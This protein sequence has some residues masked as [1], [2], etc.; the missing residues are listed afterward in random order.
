MEVWLRGTKPRPVFFE[1][2]LPAC[3]ERV[4]EFDRFDLAGGSLT[5]IFTGPESKITLAV[6]NG[7]LRFRQVFHDSFWLNDPG[8]LF[9]QDFE[10][11]RSPWFQAEMSDFDGTTGLNIHPEQR[12]PE[13]VVTLPPEVRSIGF[14]LAH[15]MEG[16]VRV[17]GEKVIAQVV[18]QDLRR[19][20]LHVSDTGADCHGN[21][22]GAAPR[23]VTAEIEESA[24]RQTMI[25]FGGT[26]IPTAFRE[27]SD[28]GKQRFWD[29][30]E[31]YNLRVQRENPI[32]GEL[33]EAMDNWDDPASAVPHYYGDSF[34]NGNISDFALNRGFQERGGQVWFEYWHFPK[35]M[36]RE[37]E[38]YIDE[39]GVERRNPVRVDRYAASI[40][41]YCRRAA[42]RT[43]RPP[44]IVGVQ[45]EQSHPKATYHKMV[46]AL[47][48]ALDEA[49][50][51][52][53]RIHMSDANMLS[54]DSS[55]GRLYADSITR[56]KTFREN[57]DTWAAIDYSTAHMYDY[58]EY[59]DD[60]DAFDAPMD[61]LHRLND[62]KPFLST[63]LCVNSPR[64]QMR[65]YRLA[66]LMGELMHKNLARLDA[67]AVLF[68]WTLL[69]VEQPTYAW[70]R[71]LLAID[72]SRGGL[73]VP[74]SHQL[75]VYGAWSRRV[76][77]GMRRVEVHHGEPDLMAVAFVGD[78]GEKTWVGLNRS[79]A[80]LRVRL[81]P[82][83][84]ADFRWME[85]VS[86]YAENAVA[87]N[88]PDDP[89]EIAPGS[90]I[91]LSNVPI[92][93]S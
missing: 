42:E 29:Y 71:A 53:V 39:K 17:N 84:P 52:E 63:E 41:D 87:E 54:P 5:W 1:E 91:T 36:T 64:Y 38:T 90:I 21:L 3:F 77:E 8:L 74:G 61:E 50:F 28:E 83:R 85:T 72:H 46:A 10:T 70:T 62:G 59:F 79:T 34:P 51:D 32:A 19:H 31:D 23:E 33:N 69:N 65:S 93:K 13:R 66:L 40:V 24:V 89:V 80:P 76:R 35:W 15:N 44:A 55:W 6:E 48:S 27:L 2:F 45:N 56:A 75:R 4:L 60:P 12:W 86:P 26:A 9:D 68:C 22:T 92:R 30:V 81:D 14:S 78:E 67:A 37:G 7:T 16:A 43:G 20:Q 25:G 49:G 47:R 18:L 88:P 11:N 82:W 73:P 57:P 58:Q